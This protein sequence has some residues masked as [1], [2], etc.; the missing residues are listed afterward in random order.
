ML[1]TSR[2]Y[3]GWHAVRRVI[4][5]SDTVKKIDVVPHQLP[6]HRDDGVFAAWVGIYVGGGFD[7]T[8]EA[9]AYDGHDF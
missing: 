8:I 5:G 2:V 9:V 3:I 6:V 4:E 1:I 7:Q